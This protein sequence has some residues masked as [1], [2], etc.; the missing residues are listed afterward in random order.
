MVVDG[1]DPLDGPLDGRI[2]GPLDGRIDGRIDPG[3]GLLQE[4]DDVGGGTA[5]RRPGECG[6]TRRLD[7]AKDVAFAAAAVV[8]LLPGALCW[9]H[10][11]LDELLASDA[12]GR[13]WPH[14]VE[15]HHHTLLGWTDV[16]RF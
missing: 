4:S 1:I 16:Q 8:D 12:L 15:A 7:R 11:R 5:R 6:A 13:L 10:P 9:P 2:D 14:L 3:V